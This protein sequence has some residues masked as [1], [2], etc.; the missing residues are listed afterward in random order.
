VIVGW[1]VG[2]VPG[3]FR[4]FRVFPGAG[5]GF[6]R[7]GDKPVTGGGFDPPQGHVPQH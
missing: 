2:L 4:D 6:N 7:V 5:W 3:V 1:L